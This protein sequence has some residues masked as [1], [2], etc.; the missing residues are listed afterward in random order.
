MTLDRRELM[1][2]AGL[3]ALGHVRPEELLAWAQA[4][5]GAQ[6]ATAENLRAFSPVQFS[7][8]DTLSENI[9]PQTDTPGARAAGVASFADHLLAEWFPDD[10]RASFLKGLDAFDSGC[11]DRF[12]AAFASASR[13]QQTAVMEESE[14]LAMAEREGFSSSPARI[15]GS[16]FFDVAKWLTLFRLLH[17]R[18][19]HA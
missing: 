17:I 4:P 6:S 11:R 10:A 12:G 2:L 15:G 5:R 8:F 13:E 19:G 9:L 16:Q 18:S 14:A 7:V 3:L 1:G